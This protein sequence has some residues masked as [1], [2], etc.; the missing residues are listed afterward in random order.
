MSDD[1]ARRIEVREKDP[2]APS[3]AMGAALQRNSTTPWAM[4]RTDMP[5]QI[6]I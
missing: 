4:S 2:K 3:A 5:G 1:R 6:L